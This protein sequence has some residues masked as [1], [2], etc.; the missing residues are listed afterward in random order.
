MDNV[1]KEILLIIKSFVGCYLHNINFYWVSKEFNS[2]NNCP[3]VYYKSLF[4]CRAHSKDPYL[5]E[6]ICKL[7]D[8]NKI[9]KQNNL[10]NSLS[11]KSLESY[12][13]ARNYFSDFGNIS[14]ICNQ[15]RKIVY[16]YSGEYFHD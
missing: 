4:D 12:N 15:K 6:S 16:D 14:Y 13:I 8:T 7:K 3:I 11:F 5:L 9:L 1:P 10:V 2:L